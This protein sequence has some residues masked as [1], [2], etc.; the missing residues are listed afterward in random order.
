MS[1]K[2]VLMLVGDFVEDYEVMVPYQIL[3]YVIFR[4]FAGTSRLIMGA[5]MCS[6]VGH[7]VDVVCPK[8]KAG[9]KVKTAV[10]DFEGDQTYTYVSPL[11]HARHSEMDCFPTLS[12]VETGRSPDTSSL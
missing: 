7:K 8:R 6:C 10:H 1:G 2:K 3:T 11:Q 5:L 12:T 9:E 4:F